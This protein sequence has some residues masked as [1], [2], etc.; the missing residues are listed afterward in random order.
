MYLLSGRRIVTDFLKDREIGKKRLIGMPDRI[1]NRVN[2]AG[3]R[4]AL[5][6][7]VINAFS[8]RLDSATVRDRRGARPLYLPPYG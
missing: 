6:P 3:G 2:L 5:R 7:T 1:T 4:S 8:G